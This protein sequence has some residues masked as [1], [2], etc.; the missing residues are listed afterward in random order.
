[1]QRVTEIARKMV[2]EWGMSDR[3][4]LVTYQS[5]SPI[6]LGRD[7]EAHNTYSEETAGVIVEEA[8]MII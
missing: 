7:M 1:M 8:Y 3:V 5:D 6:F 2:T 4:G